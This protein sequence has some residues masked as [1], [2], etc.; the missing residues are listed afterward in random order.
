M[1]C[2][3]GLAAAFALSAPVLAQGPTGFCPP[4]TTSLLT[5]WDRGAPESVGQSQNPLNAWRFLAARDGR[6]SLVGVG[7]DLVPAIWGDP[8]QPFAIP[9]FGPRYSPNAARNQTAAFRRTPSFEGV[10]FHPGYGTNDSLAQFTPS[11]A[12]RLLALSIQTEHLGNS[13]PFASVRAVLERANGTTLVLVPP[14]QILA[15]AAARTLTPGVGVLPVTLALGD[16]VIIATSS[17]DNPFEDWMNVNATL[18]IEGPPVFAAG[19]R[20]VSLCAAGTVANFS[21]AADGTASLQYRWQRREATPGS[22]WANLSNGPLLLGG[23][24]VATVSGATGAQ[25]AFNRGS[26]GSEFLLIRGFVRCV[27]TDGCGLIRNSPEAVMRFCAGDFT[28]DGAIDGDD[29]IAFFAAWDAGTFE[30]D[31]NGDGGTDGDDVIAFFNDWD[32]Q[33]A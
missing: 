1:K 21:V 4:Y 3:L 23:V 29:V 8:T 25:L 31:V 22:P 32:S 30:G 33:C 2:L 15:L 6:F 11:G 7:A 19:P 17:D 10:F 27:V 28:C 20:E 5:T 26:A 18:T 13:S 24:P 12:G 16:R 14:T 9:F